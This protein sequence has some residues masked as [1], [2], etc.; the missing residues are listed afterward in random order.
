[1]SCRVLIEDSLFKYLHLSC[2]LNAVLVNL[3]I[4]SNLIAAT[5]VDANGDEN[6]KV[7]IV[8]SAYMAGMQ[9]HWSSFI[10]PPLTE[11][12]SFNLQVEIT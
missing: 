2:I 3:A 11:F 9:A 6:H 8:A 12:T 5:P 4:N 10:T 1:M 7:P